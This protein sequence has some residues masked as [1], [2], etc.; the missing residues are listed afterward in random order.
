MRLL[1]PIA[2]LALVCGCTPAPQPPG[3]S[4]TTSQAPAAAETAPT[5]AMTSLSLR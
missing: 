1:L 5:V 4:N 2:L 3:K